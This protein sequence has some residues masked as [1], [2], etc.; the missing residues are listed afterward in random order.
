MVQIVSH[1]QSQLP[2]HTS[3]STVLLLQDERQK[4]AGQPLWRTV[5]NGRNQK[6]RF[7]TRWKVKISFWNLSS[8]LHTRAMA[9]IR[10]SYKHIRI[11][12]THVYLHH[13]HNTHLY[14]YYTPYTWTFVAHTYIIHTHTITHTYTTHITQTY[15]HTSLCTERGGSIFKDNTFK[16]KKLFC[17]FN[18]FW[19][20]IN[21]T[22]TFLSALSLCIHLVHVSL[23]DKYHIM[24][25]PHSHGDHSPSSPA[26][27]RTKC[28]LLT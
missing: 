11:H 21:L 23:H 20:N 19:K 13:I 10:M 24:L 26:Y 28:S 25:G 5:C 12:Q 2:S 7:D 27:K 3:V 22:G 9:F 4:L 14:A 15:I 18:I 17:K 1:L 6:D 16:L 8:H